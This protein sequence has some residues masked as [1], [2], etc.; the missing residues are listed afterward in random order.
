MTAELGVGVLRV[1]VCI[2]S[3][4]ALICR[5]QMLRKLC[6]AFM[7]VLAVSPF[8]A[9]FQTWVAC[10]G[11]AED[12]NRTPIVAPTHEATSDA[13]DAGSLIAPVETRQGHLLLHLPAASA[14]STAAT[15]VRAAALAAPA[16]ADPVRARV[17]QTR[18]A[19]LLRV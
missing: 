12:A 3:H 5:T 6:A 16:V 14:F 8:T 11:A 17:P 15:A 10:S 19:G 13:N 2:C 18:S 9:P 7:L 1:L 4:D